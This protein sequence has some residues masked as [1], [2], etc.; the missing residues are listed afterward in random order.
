MITLLKTN[1]E[2]T[3]LSKN[4]LGHKLPSLKSCENRASSWEKK[5]KKLPMI[6]EE[7][8][9]EKF[10]DVLFSELIRVKRRET[11]TNKRGREGYNLFFWIKVPYKSSFFIDAH[12]IRRSLYLITLTLM[13]FSFCLRSCMLMPWGSWQLLIR[14]KTCTKTTTQHQKNTTLNSWWNS[15]NGTDNEKEQQS[16]I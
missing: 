8:L 16:C 2:K 11:E 4:R 10:K 5:K 12:L 15:Q 6:K 7:G 1:P 13:L 3:F 9:S 14:P